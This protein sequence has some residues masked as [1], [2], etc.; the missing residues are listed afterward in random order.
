MITPIITTNFDGV[1]TLSLK[2][3]EMTR[4]FIPLLLILAANISQAQENP[5]IHIDKFER[6]KSA[7][8]ISGVAKVIPPGTKMWVTVL[9]FNG[10]FIEEGHTIKTL[11]DVFTRSDGSFVAALK[12]LGSLDRFDFPDGKYELEFFGAFNRAWQTVEVARKAGVKLDDQGRSDV[13]EPHALPLSSDL[14]VEKSFTG[15]KVRHLKA[16]RTINFGPTGSSTKASNTTMSDIDTDVDIGK[17]R[18]W[19]RSAESEMQKAGAFFSNRRTDSEI[20]V[21][22]RKIEAVSSQGLAIFPLKP[23]WTDCRSVASYMWPLW[24]DGY[25]GTYEGNATA[26]RDTVEYGRK[27]RENFAKCKNKKALG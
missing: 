20:G 1:V 14:P 21:Q 4:L 23:Y 2:A 19:L 10:K 26:K 25:R 3:S 9:R 18:A 5:V 6:T 22:S 8:V 17:A 16:I 13:G 7:I 12:R 24:W 11:E 27:F 15:E